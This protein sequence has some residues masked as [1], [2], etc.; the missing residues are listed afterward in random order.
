MPCYIVVTASVSFK[1]Q[2]RELFEK[3]LEAMGFWRRSELNG[4]IN[5]QTN[6]GKNIAFDLVNGKVSSQDYRQNTFNDKLNSFKRAYSVQAIEEMAKKKKWILKQQSE[7]AF[8]LK[9]Y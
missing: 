7:S 6:D 8:Q 5:V 1:A 4:I 2:N 3:T 9:R